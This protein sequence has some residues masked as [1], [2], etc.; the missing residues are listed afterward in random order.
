MPVSGADGEEEYEGYLYTTCQ[1]V[2]LPP[3]PSYLE[4]T[5]TPTI[6]LWRVSV[7]LASLSLVVAVR[8][9]F[10]LKDLN[11]SSHMTSKCGCSL[12][13]DLTSLRCH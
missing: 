6:R 5:K 10:M 8:P 1:P 7:G 13:M 3:G 2:V 12:G 11:N 4:G 9:F